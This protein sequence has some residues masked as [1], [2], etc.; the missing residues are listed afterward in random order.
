MARYII[1]Q[2]P[3]IRDEDGSLLVF[4]EVRGCLACAR[5]ATAESDR[6]T[7]CDN[8]KDTRTV[9]ISHVSSVDGR[10]KVTIRTFGND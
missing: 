8:I 9:L 7:Y 10:P 5:I 3:T 2:S 4:T 1:N 6:C